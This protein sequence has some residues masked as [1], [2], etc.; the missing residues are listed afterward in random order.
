MLANSTI[1]NAN[2]KE[3]PDLFYSLKGGGPNYCAKNSIHEAGGY[4]LLIWD[5]IYSGVVT[6][7]DLETVQYNRKNQ[8]WYEVRNYPASQTESLLQALVEYQTAA[9]EDQNAA[10]AFTTSQNTTTVGFIYSEPTPLP[11]VFSSFYPIGGFSTA[12]PSTIGTPAQLTQI[13]TFAAPPTKY[14]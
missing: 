6:R 1:L 8:V 12:V 14:V 13:F 11:S 9:A 4:F 5:I 7:F 10:L 3:H 2:I